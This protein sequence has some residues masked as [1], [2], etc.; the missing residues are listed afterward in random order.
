MRVTPDKMGKLD[1]QKCFICGRYL[2]NNTN[3][4]LAYT[5][6]HTGAKVKAKPDT[7]YLFSCPNCQKTGH[8]RC[9]YDV[10]EK[11][12]KEGW[13]GKKQWRLECPGCHQILSEARPEKVDWEHGYQIPGHPDEELIGLQIPDVLAWKAGSVVGKIGHAVDGFFKSVSVGSLSASETSAIA[14]AA[15]RIGKTLRDV[16]NMVFRLDTPAAKRSEIK[17]LKCQHCGAPLPI[18]KQFEQAVVCAHCGTAHLL[19]A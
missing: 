19:P 9:W 14:Q 1:G 8:K 7:Y 4:D 15:A 3:E 6:V 12:I 11:T 16:A 10:A 2:L 17:D 5:Q 18:P 13:F